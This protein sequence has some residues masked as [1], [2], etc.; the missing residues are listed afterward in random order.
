MWSWFTF[1]LIV[2]ILGVIIAFGPNFAFPFMGALLEKH[3][4]AALYMAEVIEVVERR[5]VLPLAVV[6]AL[7][8]TGLIF[9]AHVDLWHSEWLLISIVLY[10][11]AFFFALFVQ[12][13]TG[14]QMV[15]LLQQMPAGPP[16][17]GATGPPPEIAALA[18]RLQFGGMYLTA[19]VVVI[20]ILMIWRPGAAF[21]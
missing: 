15:R 7:A 4:E 8:G 19:S 6:V 20:A 18:K 12:L 1:Y 10:A 9:T 2:H 5:M 3:P 16:P 21:S 14:A 13:R 17:E 11:A